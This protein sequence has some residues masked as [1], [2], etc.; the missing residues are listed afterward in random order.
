MDDQPILDVGTPNNSILISPLIDENETM[1]HYP[2][3]GSSA[4]KAAK[5][6][7]SATNNRQEEKPIL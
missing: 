7:A 3:L 5:N 4:I 6:P 2:F 1:E